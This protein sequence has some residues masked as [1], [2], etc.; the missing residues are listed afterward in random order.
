M[1]IGG[2]KGSVS[3]KTPADF[4]KS[5]RGRP[6]VVKLNSGV[7]YRGIFA[8]SILFHFYAQSCIVTFKNMLRLREITC[9]WRLFFFFFFLVHES[10]LL[11]KWR[12]LSAYFFVLSYL[13][14]L[15]TL[16]Q[17]CVF[18]TLY[19]FLPFIYSLYQFLVLQIWLACKR[20]LFNRNWALEMKKKNEGIKNM[21]TNKCRK[22]GAEV[23]T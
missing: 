11:T 6:V 5:I 3:T 13:L 17:R 1:S 12:H 2:E 10:S 19:C 23:K 20:W 14:F 18:H 4:L 7:D 9:K 22:S 16:I 8:C 15:M 21:H